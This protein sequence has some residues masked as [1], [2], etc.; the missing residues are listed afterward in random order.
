MSAVLVAVPTVTQNSLHPS[1]I[2]SIIACHLLDFV[3]QGKITEADAPTIRLD[4]TPSGLLVSPP[5]SSPHFYA[6]YHFCRN[7]PNLS[8]LRAGT[9]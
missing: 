5:L 7:P 4:A 1:T 2:S 6:E 9:E 8:W 3:V